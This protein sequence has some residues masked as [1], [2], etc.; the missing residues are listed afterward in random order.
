MEIVKADKLS[1]FASVTMPEPE[2]EPKDQENKVLMEYLLKQS[3]HRKVEEVFEGYTGQPEPYWMDP[4]LA[5]LSDGMLLAKKKEAGK[6]LC[7]GLSL[8]LLRCLQPKEGRKVLHE[9]YAGD[10]NNHI[11]S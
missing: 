6:V 7:Q 3:T 9:L 5:Y 8:P 11:K 1:K 2:P 10:Y 4:I